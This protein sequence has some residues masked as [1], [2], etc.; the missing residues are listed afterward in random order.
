MIHDSDFYGVSEV[1]IL[2]KSLESEKRRKNEK[3]P[4]KRSSRAKVKPVTN[5]I[6]HSSFH[7]PHSVF[8]LLAGRIE[9]VN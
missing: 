7:I 3:Q 9:E 6:P 5:D 1:L 4:S 2:T 8:L